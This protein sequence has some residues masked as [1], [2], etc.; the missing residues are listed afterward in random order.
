[1]ST[2]TTP[3]TDLNST[4]LGCFGQGTEGDLTTCVTDGLFGAG[5]SPAVIG[6]LLAGVLLVSLYVA[7]DGTVAVPSVVTILLGSSLIPLL[8]AQYVTL[9]YTVVV[10]G[11]TVAVFAAYQRFVLQGGF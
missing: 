3:P 1:M 2:T 5:P 7:G 9:A 10:V 11:I 4:S 6:L 8:P